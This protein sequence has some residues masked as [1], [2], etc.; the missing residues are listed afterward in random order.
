MFH[1]SFDFWA[2]SGFG[3]VQS[4]PVGALQRCTS[5]HSQWAAPL[6]CR[7]RVTFLGRWC[8]R[9]TLHGDHQQR[10]GFRAEAPQPH[11]GPLKILKCSEL[12]PLREC[13]LIIKRDAAFGLNLPLKICTSMIRINRVIYPYKRTLKHGSTC[14]GRLLFLS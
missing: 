14:Y 6:G 10:P 7:D 5:Y 1:S 4:C 11:K 8:V 2:C 9:P 12:R 13:Y 3:I